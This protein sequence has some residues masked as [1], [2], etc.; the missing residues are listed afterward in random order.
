MREG[1]APR[2]K[3]RQPQR[4]GK[5]S[6]REDFR[7]LTGLC[8]GKLLGECKSAEVGCV[9]MGSKCEQGSNVCRKRSR[10]QGGRVKEGEPEGL[11]A[12]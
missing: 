12:L 6:S 2:S 4:M 11:R 8:L 3:V 5:L 9:E 7:H 1:E 10:E